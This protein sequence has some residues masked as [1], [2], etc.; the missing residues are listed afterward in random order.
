MLHHLRVERLAVYPVIVEKSFEHEVD[1]ERLTVDI[2]MLQPPPHVGQ[3]DRRWW[4]V[5]GALDVTSHLLFGRQPVIGVDLSAGSSLGD[6][7]V[8]LRRR[9]LP[10]ILHEFVDETRLGRRHGR[11]EVRVHLGD[12]IHPVGSDAVQMVQRQCPWKVH[13]HATPC[14]RSVGDAVGDRDAVSDHAGERVVHPLEID[15]DGDGALVR[16]G[17]TPLALRSVEHA[18]SPC[19][20][21]TSDAHSMPY[22][23]AT[24]QDG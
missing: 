21:W 3:C 6:A 7:V 9:A 19:L 15:G 11:C 13:R 8:L 1:A 10:K 22:L 14:L 5:R 12:S 16:I 4:C 2:L 17:T 18:F 23:Q 24:L 20:E